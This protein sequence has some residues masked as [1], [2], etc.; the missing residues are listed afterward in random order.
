MLRNRAKS[1]LESFFVLYVLKIQLIKN[2]KIKLLSKY[3][4]I[5]SY[6]IFLDT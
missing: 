4:E 1:E 2:D 5:S 6:H 3:F